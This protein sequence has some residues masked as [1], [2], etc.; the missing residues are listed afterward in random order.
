MSTTAVPGA[1]HAALGSAPTLPDTHPMAPAAPTA[2]PTDATA[3]ARA[4]ARKGAIRPPFVP[5]APPLRSIGELADWLRR[6]G[7][8]AVTVLADPAVAGQSVTTLVCAQV[9]AAGLDPR[10]VTLDPAG[11]VRATTELAALLAPGELVIGI[12]GG[13]TLDFAKLAALTAARPELPKYLN[14]PQ[15]SGFL[16]LPPALGTSVRVLAVPTTL[17]T[18]SELG[19]VACFAKDGAK[20]L[21]TGAC[22]RPVAAL[23]T[24]EATA[25]LPP[26]L[27]ADGVLEALFRTVSPYA[28]DHTD[29]PEQD[30]QVEELTARLLAAG[31]H[32]AAHRAHG[33]PVPAELRLRIA[34]M[35]G[36]SQIGLL[37][38]GRSPYAVKCWAIANELSTTLNLAKMRTVSALWP[39]LWRRTLAGDTRLGS[40]DRIRRLWS[41]LR[42]HAP[43]LDEDPADGL[44]ALMRHW[45][46]DRTVTATGTEIARATTRT[47]R[48]W[49]AG[50]PIL[51][52]LS[53]AD[54]RALLTEAT[55]Q[56][57]RGAAPGA[58]G[59]QDHH[60]AQSPAR[61]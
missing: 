17:G 57:A 4:R 16:V 43:W 40:P 54:V 15:R 34:E 24:A 46:I 41:T 60:G 14:S 52:E 25:T 27:I 11:G 26:E 47:M 35:S 1:R 8:P 9:R 32:V 21:A 10:L 7:A 61:P 38:I 42:N 49:G 22:L 55:D 5:P 45:H 12:G 59:R 28:G 30:A 39:V 37:N 2:A 13:T 19:T 44:L 53:A 58:R 33:T 48:A 3:P 51:D 18:G 29:L 20:L 50:L 31:Y 23:W 6:D 36:E 56:A